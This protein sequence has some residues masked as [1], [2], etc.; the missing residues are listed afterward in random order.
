MIDLAEWVDPACPVNWAHHLNRDLCGWWMPVVG[1]NGGQRVYDLCNR[2]HAS[3][4]H[5][6]DVTWHPPRG[7][8]GH[9]HRSVRTTGVN[10]FF[11]QGL[12]LGTNALLGM[13]TTSWPDFTLSVDCQ[14]STQVQ[15]DGCGLFTHHTGTFGNGLQVSVLAGFVNVAFT[16]GPGGSVAVPIST[17]FQFTISKV[18]TAWSWY[19][20]GVF[21]ETITTG[22]ATIPGDD[23]QT[24]TVFMTPG[25]ETD[26]YCYFWSGKIW[27]H[28]LTQGEI[29]EHYKLSMRGYPEMLNR[30]SEP[31]RWVL[32]FQ[33]DH[34]T[35]VLRTPAR[36]DETQAPVDPA[37]PVNWEHPLNRERRLWVLGVTNSGWTGGKTWRGLVRNGRKPLDGALSSSPAGV[38][39]RSGGYSGGVTYVT[40]SAGETFDCGTPVGLNGGTNCTLAG[41]VYKDS[42]GD[43]TYFGGVT[44]SGGTGGNRFAVQW[45]SD[46]VL[47]CVAEGSSAGFGFHQITG[48]SL[49]WH[50]V[51]LVFDGSQASNATRLRVYVNG[52]PQTGFTTAGTIPASLGTSTGPI[53]I[54]KGGD[55]AFGSGSQAYS[56][57]TFWSRSLSAQDASL[58]YQLSRQGYPGALNRLPASTA[59]SWAE[60]PTPSYRPLFISRRLGR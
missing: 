6:T 36:Q 38:W 12:S 30:L 53:V 54:G 26:P 46:G 8:R 21:Q 22:G 17:P 11:S 23:T 4:T 33:P 49:G 41:W 57:V 14:L 55:L 47:Y 13:G 2:V 28:G 15:T 52:K 3:F 27:K 44:G 48:L 18:G 60:M 39:R 43:K 34:V 45:H 51:M 58:D 42:A 32:A 7:R 25:S 50:R 9:P 16:N 40:P 19:R 59:F 1:R 31:K 10:R 5:A 37:N 29:A 20:D 56:D 35:N 24:K